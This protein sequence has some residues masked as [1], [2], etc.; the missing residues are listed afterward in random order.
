[1]R[2]PDLQTLN[3]PQR[4]AVTHIDGP[5]LVL[6]GAGSGKTRVITY[7]IAHLVAEGI[8]PDQIVAVSFT[9]KAAG[10]MRERV[11]EL[12]GPST[13]R[14]LHLSTFHALGAQLLRE[15]A[16]A[17]GLQRPFP[18]VDEGE[19][20][21]IVRSVLRELRLDG[22]SVGAAQ[23]LAL[24]SRAK[25]AMTSPARLPEARFNPNVPRAQRVFEH[26]E[27][28]LRNLNAVDFDDLLLMPTLM[29]RKHDELRQKY[30]QRFRYIMVDEFQD[31]NAIQLAMLDTLVDP[32]TRNLVVVGDDDQSIYG[33]RGAVADTI[34]NFDRMFPGARIVTLDQNYRSV[35]S[36]LQ[37]ANAVIANNSKRRD[38]A[39]WSNLGKGH[40]IRSVS[41]PTPTSEADFVSQWIESQA[42]HEQRGW[43]DFAILYRSNT[44]A[45][46]FEEA[47][48]RN[49]IPYRVIGGQSIFDNKEVRDLLA[50]LRL[51]LQPRD[52]LAL[53]RII[54]VPARGIGT[55][56]LAGLI[57]K[58]RESDEAL[59]DVLCGEL[60]ADAFPTRAAEA[61]R[62]FVAAVT[63]AREELE[64]LSPE[65][66]PALIER[67][68]EDIGLQAAVYAGEP[69]VHQA[70]RKWQA[71]ESLIE[72]LKNINGLTALAKLENWVGMVSLDASNI[73]SSSEDDEGKKV[74]L[75][76]IHA[77]KGLEFPLVFLVGMNENLLPHKRA[78]E[79]PGGVE[80]ERRLCYVGMTRAQQRLV[81]TRSRWIPTKM[82]KIRLRP[83]RFLSEIPKEL[84]QDR[85]LQGERD[86]A[87]P[88]T[89]QTIATMEAALELLNKKANNAKR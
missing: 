83:S 26:Y 38:K 57:E 88:D 68:V 40:A 72:A 70:K 63:G 64:K 5:M 75:M 60:A 67:F 22:S 56:T 62:T 76:T 10:E 71:V 29:L 1:M 42:H 55:Q 8:P 52:E 24:I 84:L 41:L 9:N 30:Q 3:P 46:A 32:A 7:R 49:R 79:E 34:L 16:K 27:R 33:F 20:R 89:E 87:P 48:R 36:V 78:L 65:E 35:G 14:E 21:R 53:R 45:A 23:L 43:Q 17:A 15:N 61:A 31:T 51:L 18:I 66:L 59:W 39:L 25:N 6:A 11:A 19:R 77:S 37:A 73:S 58:A 80:E 44:Q 82:G 12:V 28:S 13:A 85:E 47:L 54:N 50:Y 86:Y 74:T 69:S 4:Q 2:K 81:L